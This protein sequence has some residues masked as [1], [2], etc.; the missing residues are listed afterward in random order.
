MTTESLYQPVIDDA[1]RRE[2][3][4]LLGAAGLLTACGSDLETRTAAT[5]T[6]ETPLGPVDVPVRAQR[7]VA[8]DRFAPIAFDLGVP[9]VA[10]TAN[11]RS[12]KSDDQRFV[13]LPAADS[14]DGPPLIEVILGLEPDLILAITSQI[15]NVR[16]E[17]ARIAPLVEVPD[18]LLD[19]WPEMIRVAALAAG[20]ENAEG[21]LD[22]IDAR[23][24]EIAALDADLGT[25]AIIR[26]M[27]DGQ[28]RVYG[29]GVFSGDL[30]AWAGFDVLR[31]DEPI[32][33]LSIERLGDVTS[34]RIFLWTTEGADPAE[35]GSK[36]A[37]IENNPL[38]ARLPAVAAGRAL[39]VGEHW[40]GLDPESAH[41]VLDDI[42]R[43]SQ[44]P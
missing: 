25:A 6:I 42:Q 33:T 30:L 7:V 41:L 17:L 15:E 22:G 18:E 23:A 39:R 12:W 43:S 28:F 31:L 5:R 20:L 38:W 24:A 27:G 40:F 19:E 21:V 13:D 16:D 36:I 1:T 4:A 9:L 32:T 29:P 11:V 14:T 10:R 37:D 3:I 34:D 35:A 44:L 2:F 8:L 26:A